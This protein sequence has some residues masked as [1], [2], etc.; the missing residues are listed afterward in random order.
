MDRVAVVTGARR[1]I[2]RAIALALA[3]EGARVLAVARTRER[4]DD[5]AAEG[6]AR[7]AKVEPFV[8][9]V[10]SERDVRALADHVAT[11]FGRL[12]VLGA[13]L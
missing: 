11:R 3:D 7:G 10:S 5:V 9:D 4:L 8:C 6:R 2:G 1:G 12:D 13:T